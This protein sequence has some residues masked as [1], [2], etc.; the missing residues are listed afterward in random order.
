MPLSVYVLLDSPPDLINCSFTNII[1]EMSP[2]DIIKGFFKCNHQFT[3]QLMQHAT[4][5]ND[6]NY[7]LMDLLLDLANWSND[8]SS[9]GTIILCI[10]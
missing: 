3:S 10:I 7:Q 4:S 2:H 5:S 8:A 9:L 1:G 6:A